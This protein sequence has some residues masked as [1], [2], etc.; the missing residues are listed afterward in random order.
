MADFFD[1]SLGFVYI[2]IGISGVVLSLIGCIASFICWLLRRAF[3]KAIP[4]GY[5]VLAMP[6]MLLGII[7]GVEFAAVPLAF[8]MA[9]VT[10]FLHLQQLSGVGKSKIDMLI[11]GALL[12]G[13]AAILLSFAL[14]S[15]SGQE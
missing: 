13:L 2:Q 15:L 7:P 3:L 10:C 6:P 11:G 5:V 14:G 4:S 1:L 8:L 12:L 9:C